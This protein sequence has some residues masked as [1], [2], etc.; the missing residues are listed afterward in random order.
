MKQFN[1]NE[2][3]PLKYNQ[4]DILERNDNKE[5]YLGERKEDNKKVVIKQINLL[6]F[7]EQLKK[8]PKKKE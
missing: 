2:L 7:D 1:D 5:V 4:I 8:K 3:L 6:I